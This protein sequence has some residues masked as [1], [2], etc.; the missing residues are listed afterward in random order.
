MRAPRCLAVMSALLLLLG[1]AVASAQ[2]APTGPTDADF[3]NSNVLHRLDILINSKDWEKL[4]LNYLS[5][6]YYPCDI[7]WQGLTVRNVGVRSRGLGSRSQ[8]KP[9]LRIDFNYYASGQTFLGLKSFLLDNLWQDPSGIR[10][11]AAMQMY[12]RLNLPVPRESF[13]TV[14]VNNQYSGVYGV[15][16]SIDKEFLK[17]VFGEKDGDTENDGYLFEYKWTYAWYFTYLGS[18]LEPYDTLF[19][20]KQHDNKSTFDKYYDI[21]EWVRTVN[22]ARDDMFVDSVWKYLDLNTFM[23][24]VAAESFMAEWDGILGYAGMANFYLYRFEQTTRHQFIIWDADNTFRAVDYSIVQGHQEN[25]IMRRAMQVEGL[26]RVYFESLLAAEEKASEEDPDE[27][28]PA[29]QAKRG[30]LERE[31]DRL[32]TLIQ[33]AM[34]AD[35]NK[36]YTNQEFDEA[37]ATL[38]TF[39]RERGQFVRCEV[40]RGSDLLPLEPACY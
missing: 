24:T 5:N 31:V 37:S 8:S 35:K 34:Y 40:A 25:A 23:Q 9:G 1:A 10:E 15:I 38:R 21:E 3:F 28:V 33:S 13:A 18:D 7:K 11:V 19:D 16:E 26:R 30:W 20:E 32:I 12:A 4:K 2:S 36:P 29:G 39:A 14:Y 27:V 17:R 22:V 6:D